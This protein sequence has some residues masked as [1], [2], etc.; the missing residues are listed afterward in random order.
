MQSAKWDWLLAPQLAQ[1]RER[2]LATQTVTQLEMLLAWPMAQP[3]ARWLVQP[4][5]RP[6]ERQLVWS[7]VTRWEL[8]SVPPTAQRLARKLGLPLEPQWATPTVSQ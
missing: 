6:R 4:R 3:M 2:P 7:R 8:R 1:P 5:E